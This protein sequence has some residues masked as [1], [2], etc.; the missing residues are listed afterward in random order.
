MI[1]FAVKSF[2]MNKTFPLIAILLQFVFVSQGQTDSS[3]KSSD[4]S[5]LRGKEKLMI[6]STSNA[7]DS[8]R[9]ALLYVYRPRN[10]T[11]SAVVYDLKMTN[12][13][14]K[15]LFVGRV[16]NNSKF[17]VKLHQ[18]GTT[19]IFAVTES[20]RVVTINVK[21]GH[22][23]YLKCGVTTGFFVGRP[24]LNLVYPEQGEL[25]FDNIIVK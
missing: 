6:P 7:C 22:K 3:S 18:E 23:Y 5:T 17:V 21:F 13:V 24:E 14:A 19:E 9:Y 8:T 12:P 10:F 25:D 15:N 1:K 20:K 16:K 11:G 2:V 4:T